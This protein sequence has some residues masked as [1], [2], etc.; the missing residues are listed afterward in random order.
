MLLERRVPRKESEVDL[1]LSV[2]PDEVNGRKDDDNK[3]KSYAL[4]RQSWLLYREESRIQLSSLCSLCFSYAFFLLLK[5][6]ISKKGH[7][8]YSKEHSSFSYMWSCVNWTSL[9]FSVTSTELVLWI[10][11]YICCFQSTVILI[12]SSNLL[13]TAITCPLSLQVS[14]P[15]SFSFVLR[16]LEF[17]QDYWCDHGF[18]NICWGLVGSWVD[19]QLKTMTAPSP[20]SIISS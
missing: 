13:P 2:K 3:I 7:N 20:E 12:H 14:F 9:L 6:N 8:V 19:I 17:N 15:H 10:Y 11:I 18:G 4:L 5:Q 1:Y 16:P